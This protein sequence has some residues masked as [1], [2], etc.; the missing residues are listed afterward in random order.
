[1]SRSDHAD[2][3]KE[4]IQYTTR[5]V[6]FLDVLGFKDLIRQAADLAKAVDIVFHLEKSLLHARGSSAEV[7]VRMF[8]DCISMSSPPTPSGLEVLF[9][10]CIVVQGLL[11]RHGYLLRGAI[12]EGKHYESDPFLKSSL[13]RLAAER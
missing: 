1:M 13:A 2:V 3:T 8:S 12:T 6:A 9:W 4:A 10:R 11:L 5:L 7:S